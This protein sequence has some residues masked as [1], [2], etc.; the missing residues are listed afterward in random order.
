MV[1]N[2]VL[3]YFVTGIVLIKPS[4]KPLALAMGI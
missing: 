2:R 3:F 4:V 1:N